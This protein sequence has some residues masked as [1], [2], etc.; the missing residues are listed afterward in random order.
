MCLLSV[1]GI[2]ILDMNVYL[3]VLCWA[4]PLTLSKGVRFPDLRESFNT[5]FFFFLGHRADKVKLLL[6][7]SAL[8]FIL[9]RLFLWPW[10]KPQV[11]KSVIEVKL[12][13]LLLLV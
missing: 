10:L 8:G 7:I 2:S 11:Q 13:Y 6:V 3:S 12:N 9:S 4:N 5:D 1:H